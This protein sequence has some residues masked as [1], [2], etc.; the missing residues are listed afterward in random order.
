MPTKRN[1]WNLC[2]LCIAL[3]P[4]AQPA[5]T[6]PV[7]TILPSGTRIFSIND[8]GAV[9]GDDGGGGFLRTPDGTLTVFH[10][11]G[12]AGGTLALSINANDAITGLYLDGNNDQHGFVRSSDGT[13]TTFD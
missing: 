6:K 1:S 13:I 12:D 10:V 11:P 3:V 9:T 8:S 7:Y 5:E 2:C 4:L